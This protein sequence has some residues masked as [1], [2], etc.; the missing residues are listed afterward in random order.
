MYEQIVCYPVYSQHYSPE[1]FSASVTFIQM[2]NPKH[3]AHLGMLP[4]PSTLGVKWMH[5]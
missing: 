3:I 4:W 5:F 1:S 2:T